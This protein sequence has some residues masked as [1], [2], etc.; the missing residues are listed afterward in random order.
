MY[1]SKKRL[2][3]LDADGTTIDAYSAIEK[4]FSRHG[5][6]LG[7]E[8]SFQK[9]HHLFKYL[10]GIKQFPSNL[11]K[12]IRKKQREQIIDTLTDVYRHEALLYPGIADF[13][14]TLI[15]AP[16]IV[17]GMVTRNITNDPLETLRYLF[18]RHDV[19]VAELDFFVHVPL[20]EQ[21]TA[22]FRQ[23]RE[24]FEINPAR[25]YICGDEH[26]D[27]LAAIQT[28]MHPFMVSYGFEDLQRLTAKF[29]IPKEI[30]SRTPQELCVRVLHA[31]ELERVN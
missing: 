27:F 9:R 29:D 24:R 28:G 25:S 3:I 16:D 5:M 1:K 14:R 23:V 13:I 19:D 12:N 7:D 21:K 30:I 18:A 10:G 26:K 2:L 31:V 11:R 20:D 17:V 4:T 8:E 22:H 6:N 15:A